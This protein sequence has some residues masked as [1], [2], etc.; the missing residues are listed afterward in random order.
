MG[1]CSLSHQRPK[2]GSN[3]YDFFR[4]GI[5]V[6]FSHS[7]STKLNCTF[8]VDVAL[9]AGFS[10][11]SRC[12]QKT[13]SLVHKRLFFT[14]SSSHGL[15]YISTTEIFRKITFARQLRMDRNTFQALLGILGPWITRQNTHFR[16]CMPPEKVSGLGIYRLAHGNSYVSMGPVFNFD[17]VIEAV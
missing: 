10:L 14:E 12:F 8:Y 11:R 17:T 13:Q 3:S 5:F 9:S 7:G 15:R 2:H 6:E 1:S 16:D 4:F